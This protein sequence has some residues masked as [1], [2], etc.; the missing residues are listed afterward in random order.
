MTS[1]FPRTTKGARQYKATMLVSI[2]FALRFISECDEH[3]LKTRTDRF[4][5]AVTSVRIPN[6]SAMLTLFRQTLTQARLS[7]LHTLNSQHIV[8]FVLQLASTNLFA[9]LAS[10][11]TFPLFPIQH[12]ALLE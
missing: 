11:L 6:R 5:S 9:R 12:K 7:E 3:C 10:Q 4:D 8:A 1:K 2:A